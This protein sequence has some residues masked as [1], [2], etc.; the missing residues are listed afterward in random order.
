MRSAVVSG[1]RAPVQLMD[2]PS[3][4]KRKVAVCASKGS[5]AR[6]TH[7]NERP[8][9]HELAEAF[10]SKERGVQVPKASAQ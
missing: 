2:A 3:T 9:A 6:E 1:P 8:T 7:R 4:T 5:A 10:E